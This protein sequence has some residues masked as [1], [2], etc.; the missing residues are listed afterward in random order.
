MNI[1]IYIILVAMPGIGLNPLKPLKNDS[2][3]TGP[4]VPD[5]T[6]T[7]E[8]LKKVPAG[9]DKTKIVVCII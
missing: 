8:E 3:P 4:P 2:E 5:V 9:V 7:L 6:Y 1:V